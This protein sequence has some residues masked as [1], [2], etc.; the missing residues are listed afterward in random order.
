MNHPT[1]TVPSRRTAFSLIELIVA[2]AIVLVLS[3]LAFTGYRAL[4]ESANEAKSANNLRQLGSAVDLYLREHN[5][6]YFPYREWDPDGGFRYWFGTD[7]G[8]GTG[9]EGDREILAERGPLHPYINSV[10]SIDRCPGFNWDHPSYKPKWRDV[11]FGY[12]YNRLLGGKIS[13][14]L[15]RPADT[16]VFG[17]CAQVNTFQEP[18]SPTNPM[19]EEFYYFDQSTA[20]AHFRFGRGE[21]ALFLFADGHVDAL[22]PAEGTLDGRLPEARIGRIAPVGSLEHLW[23]P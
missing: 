6:R 10:G 11:G 13:H 9:A 14:R 16:I 19:F 3:T 8:L 12:G 23:Y 22:P 1:T 20:S 2:I 15:K 18:A 21:R 17:T 4:V 7:P 5:H